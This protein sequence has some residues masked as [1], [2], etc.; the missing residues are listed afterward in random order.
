MGT[1]TYPPRVRRTSALA[2][3]ATL[4]ARSLHEPQPISNHPVGSGLHTL[5]GGIDPGNLHLRPQVVGVGEIWKD[6]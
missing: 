5:R 2:Q 6:F 1:G 4:A 3:G